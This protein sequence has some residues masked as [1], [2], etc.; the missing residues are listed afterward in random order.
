MAALIYVDHSRVR[1]GKLAKVREKAAALGG[2]TVTVHA[3][4]AGFVR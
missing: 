2:A 4:H 3:L 1:P